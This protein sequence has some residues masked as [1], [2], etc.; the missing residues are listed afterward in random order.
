MDESGGDESR[1]AGAPVE[2]DSGRFYKVDTTM[3]A[4]GRWD[5]VCSCGF[6]STR[7]IMC[8]HTYVAH[9]FAHNTDI[10]NFAKLWSTW[11]A[12]CTQLGS[13]GLTP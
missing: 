9:I 5:D 12:V 3:A 2:F 1:G 10:N 7:Q 13:S 6:G 4:K 11:Q 8:K